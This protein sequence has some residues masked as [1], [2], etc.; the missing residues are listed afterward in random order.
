MKRKDIVH[1]AA[2]VIVSI[3][4]VATGLVL[5]AVSGK[6]IDENNKIEGNHAKQR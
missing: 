2:S 3:A 1:I 5:M 6:N 4:G